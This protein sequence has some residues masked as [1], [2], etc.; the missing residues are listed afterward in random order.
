MGLSPAELRNA[1]ALTFTSTWLVAWQQLSQQYNVMRE[2]FEAARAA[3]HRIPKPPALLTS[4]MMDEAKD[5]VVRDYFS[6]DG[7][8]RGARDAYATAIVMLLDDALKPL[9][10]FYDR[11]P[12]VED[13]NVRV[14]GIDLPTIFRDVA[15]NVRHYRD[16]R[17]P[18]QQL[19]RPETAVA[20]ATTI[21]TLM[22]RPSPTRDDVSLWANNWAWPILARVSEETFDGL[23]RL[24]VASM[25]EML[26]NAGETSLIEHVL[27]YREH[28]PI[29]LA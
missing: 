14:E 16:W 6:D 23:M 2:L 26:D 19:A 17:V 20:N 29:S 7:A 8:A 24:V 22:G 10:V 4:M 27:Y 1:H 21:A 11:I 5:Q 12:D 28:Y 13:L 3:N 25:D 9:K 15:N 18:P